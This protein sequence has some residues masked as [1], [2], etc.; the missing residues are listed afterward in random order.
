VQPQLAPQA[1]VLHLIAGYW[2]ARAVF[3][4]ARLKLADVVG[5]KA[6][7]PA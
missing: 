2:L 6:T 7:V 3:V 4:A 1:A 5:E